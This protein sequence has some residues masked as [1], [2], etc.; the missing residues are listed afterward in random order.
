APYNKA[1]EGAWILAH[2]HKLPQFPQTGRTA[3]TLHKPGFTGFKHGDGLPGLAW[4]MRQEW[5]VLANLFL[6]LMG[7]ALLSRHL[8][9]SRVP[10]EMPRFLPDD[11]KG[12]SRCS[13]SLPS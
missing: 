1:Q 10:D 4:H 8:E 3:V 12:G 9:K 13:S 5:L 6:L 7:F 2:N 11:W